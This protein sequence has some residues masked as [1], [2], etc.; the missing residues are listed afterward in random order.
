MAKTATKGT[1]LHE[2]AWHGR[3]CAECADRPT[4]VMLTAAESL[5]PTSAAQKRFPKCSCGTQVADCT[6]SEAR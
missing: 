6:L 1:T 2:I 4:Q 3:G 5:M